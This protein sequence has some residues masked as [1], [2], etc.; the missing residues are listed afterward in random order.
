MQGFY[1]S[2]NFEIASVL[3]S[4]W[5]TIKRELNYLKERDFIP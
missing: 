2:N 1:E 3:E 4:N 5:Q